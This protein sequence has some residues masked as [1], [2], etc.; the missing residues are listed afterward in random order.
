MDMVNVIEA[1]KEKFTWIGPLKKLEVKD[2]P[3]Y[4]WYSDRGKVAPLISKDIRVEF[5]DREYETVK[6]VIKGLEYLKVW[7]NK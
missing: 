5:P 4:F 7:R 1:P 6:E 3:I 2:G